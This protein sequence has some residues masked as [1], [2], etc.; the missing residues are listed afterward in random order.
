MKFIIYL[1]MK[2]FALFVAAIFAVTLSFG[3]VSCDKYDDG[4][5]EFNQMYPD[6]R[7]VEWEAEAGY[8][9]VSFETGKAPNRNDH[10]AWYAEDGTWVRTVSEYPLSKVPQGIRDLLAGSEYGTL[11]LEDNEVEFFETSSYGKF[12]RFDLW[13]NGREIKVDV[14]ESGEVVPASYDVM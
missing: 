9:K 5:N 11:P 1:V 10:E 3:A 2:R 4:R 6:A 12:Y 7:D 8:W 14:H 13:Q